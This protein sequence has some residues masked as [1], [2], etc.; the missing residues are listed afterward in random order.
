MSVEVPNTEKYCL[1]VVLALSVGVVVGDVSG[2]GGLSAFTGGVV[3]VVDV[4][5]DRWWR[6]VNLRL[7]FS[8]SWSMRSSRLWRGVVV[9]GVEGGGVVV[10]GVVVMIVGAV[11]ARIAARRKSSLTE[12]AIEE[13]DD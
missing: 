7:A 3:V 8:R 6:L 10:V 11:V 5:G 9:I 2:V 1:V 13:I 4:V 12:N